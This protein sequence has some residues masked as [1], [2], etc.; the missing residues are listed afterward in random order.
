M[1]DSYDI[2]SAAKI[3]PFCDPRPLTKGAIGGFIGIAPDRQADIHKFAGFRITTRFS[4]KMSHRVVTSQT[5]ELPRA[6][7]GMRCFDGTNDFSMAVAT[8][9]LGDFTTVRLDLNIV[10]IAAGGEKE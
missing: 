9:L 10:L 4:L 2:A 7:H 8:R 1:I 6:R 3:P 5:G